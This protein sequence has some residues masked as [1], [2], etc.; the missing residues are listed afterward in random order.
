MSDDTA[1]VSGNRWEPADP[2]G[3]QVAEQAV[4]GAQP[5]TPAPGY[6]PHLGLPE[7]AV[8]GP[9]PRPTL[10]TR[11]RAGIAGGAAVVLLAGGIGGFA[12]GRA[13][14]GDGGQGVVDRQGVPTGFDRD[15]D[16]DRGFQGGPGGVPPNG[17]GSDGQPPSGQV[18]GSGA[19]DNGQQSSTESDTQDS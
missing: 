9:A 17:S 19:D 6:Q 7:Y 10:L 11:A 1:P 15:G 16:G 5:A 2:P 12:I 14:A 3:E 8:A 13:T 18:P 4:E